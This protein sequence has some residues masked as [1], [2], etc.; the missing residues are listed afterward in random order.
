MKHLQETLLSRNV[1]A[2]REV[3]WFLWDRYFSFEKQIV[4]ES[5]DNNIIERV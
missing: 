1:R 3:Q 5:T 4:E 2:G